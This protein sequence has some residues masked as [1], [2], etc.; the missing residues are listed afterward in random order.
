MLPGDLAARRETLATAGLIF[1]VYADLVAHQASERRVRFG[2]KY[3]AIEGRYSTTLLAPDY[4]RDHW[5]KFGF[6][7]ETVLDGIIDYRQDL[8]VLRRN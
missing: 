4:I 7:V 8:V 5:A 2:S 6:A 3:L 1:Q